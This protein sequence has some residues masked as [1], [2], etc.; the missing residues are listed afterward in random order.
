MGKKPRFAV[1][2]TNLI[3]DKVMGVFHSDVVNINGLIK[4]F[5]VNYGVVPFGPFAKFYKE[6]L[7]GNFG[8][9]FSF[10]GRKIPRPIGQMTCFVF[11]RG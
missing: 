1:V 2:H 4:V 5:Y 9:F 8:P 7:S 10:F 11:G 3:S 6:S